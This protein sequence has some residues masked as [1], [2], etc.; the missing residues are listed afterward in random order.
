MVDPAFDY[1]ENNF[2]L[3]EVFRY[4]DEL[5]ESGVTNMYGASPSLIEEFDCT[6]GESQQLLKKWMD[7]FNERHNA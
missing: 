6:R 2:D 7:T 3:E 5:R 4:L 1:L